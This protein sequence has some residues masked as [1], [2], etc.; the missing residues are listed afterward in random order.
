MV[1]ASPWVFL[2]RTFEIFE[3]EI[4]FLIRGDK[5]RETAMVSKKD[6]KRSPEAN[7]EIP[8]KIAFEILVN[9]YFW[10]L[11]VIFPG[12]LKRTDDKISARV[13]A[14]KKPPAFANPAGIEKLAVNSFPKKE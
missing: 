8:P 12:S 13:A 10:I 6:T 5:G 4:F 9:L 14:I 7:E 11:L 2:V 3:V 1:F